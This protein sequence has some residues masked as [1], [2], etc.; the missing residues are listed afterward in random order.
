[1]FS[2]IH[3]FSLAAVVLAGLLVF[4]L[5]ARACYS[6]LLL[7]PTAET[8]PA[9]E[10]SLDLQLDGDATVPEVNTYLLNTEFGLNDRVEA[11]IDYLFS[12]DAGE[13]LMVNAKYLAYS[14]ETRAVALGI[15]NLGGDRKMIP[16]VTAL[17]DLGAV[18]GHLGA[19]RND[20]K[21][22][23]FVGVDRAVNDRLTLL[24][25]YISG[26]ENA[27]SLGVS[28]A[29]N[30]RWSVCPGLVFPNEDSATSFTVHLVYGGQ[31]RRGNE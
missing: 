22:R 3:R 21:I 23:W 14:A 7:I 19:Q 9:G 20:G 5:P 10:Y 29:I 26:D 12:G 8:V 13:R 31:Y 27:A 24:A 25:D 16:Y 17:Q 11:G 28:Y 1:M 15:Y 30:D 2:N 4:T 18:R 6:G